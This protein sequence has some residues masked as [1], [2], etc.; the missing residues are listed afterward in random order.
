MFPFQSSG[1]RAKGAV[2]PYLT[3]PFL[4]SPAESR[5]QSANLTGLFIVF[6]ALISYCAGSLAGRLT[7]GLAFA[8]AALL[9]GVLQGVGS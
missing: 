7:G 6:A 3:V 2:S 8:A 5:N 1:T 4:S 9:H